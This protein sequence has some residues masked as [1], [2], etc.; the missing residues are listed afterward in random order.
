MTIMEMIIIISVFIVG[1]LLGTYN[2]LQHLK[3]N[4]YTLFA[5]LITQ[6]QKEKHEKSNN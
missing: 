3:K 4:P 6:H 2:M 1:W 5:L